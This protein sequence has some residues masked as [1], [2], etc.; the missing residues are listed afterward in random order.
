ME[1]QSLMDE[2]F[3]R[4]KILEEEAKVLEK[5]YSDLDNEVQNKKVAKTS[6][7]WL[8]D[9]EKEENQKKIDEYNQKLDNYKKMMDE[10]LNF[11]AAE[12]SPV[13][14]KNPK[15]DESE[16]LNFLKLVNDEHK[17]LTYERKKHLDKI[18][19]T[20]NLNKEEDPYFGSLVDEFNKRFK[21]RIIRYKNSNYVIKHFDRSEKNIKA[22]MLY[23]SNGIKVNEQY[24]DKMKLYNSIELNDLFENFFILSKDESLIIMD[25]FIKDNKNFIK[26]YFQMQT[27]KRY[28]IEK[29]LIPYKI[30]PS[31]IDINEYNL[32]IQTNT[33]KHVENKENNVFVIFDSVLIGDAKSTGFVSSSSI[34]VYTTLYSK[35]IINILHIH[36]NDTSLDI[37]I[38]SEFL[39]KEDKVEKHKVFTVDALGKRL[40]YK[41]LFKDYRLIK[42]YYSVSD[43]FI[44]EPPFEEIRIAPNNYVKIIKGEYKNYYGQVKDF[45]LGM[46]ARKDKEMGELKRMSSSGFQKEG[47]CPDRHLEELPGFVSVEVL[48][49]NGS[50]PTKLKDSVNISIPVC[51]LIPLSPEEQVKFEKSIIIQKE[52]EIE[53]ANQEIEEIYNK[54]TNYENYIK[55]DALLEEK[56]MDEVKSILA[57]VEKISIEELEKNSSED[58]REKL[59]FISNIKNQIQPILIQKIRYFTLIGKK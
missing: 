8:S 36:L 10:N 56:T 17:R 51:F 57:E 55:N 49:K 27:D 21:G 7:R 28:P 46:L 23:D 58:F 6:K 1:G 12:M 32:T 59:D 40:T 5:E 42:I 16:I 14:L 30:E 15:F 44:D 26:I 24:H 50:P 43:T 9:Q 20:I 25:E 53:E 29:D 38:D 52:M 54:C 39:E 47:Y 41:L 34:K 13:T 37:T 3:E 31:Y 19:Q 2:L 4:I 33:I 45:P 11:P 48:F 18:E 22:L 35:D